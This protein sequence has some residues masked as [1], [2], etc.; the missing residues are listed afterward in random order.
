MKRFS[1]IIPVFNRPN[2]VDELLDSLTRQSLQNFEVL[3][4]EDGSQLRCEE[5]VK[6]YHDKL[7]LKYFFKDNSG[8]GL[9]RNYGAERATED[10]FIFFD[11]DCIIPEDYFKI[12]SQLYEKRPFHFYG[13]VDRAHSSFTPIQKAID[14]SMTSFLT[15]GGI[16]GGVKKVTKFYPRS[17]NMGFSREV[18]KATGGFSTMR[19]GEDIDFSLR[20]EREGF[21]PLLIN[22]AYVYHKRRTDFKKFYKQIFNSGI[23]RINLYKRFPH[24]LKLTHF[25]PAAFLIF[26][27]LSVLS[28]IL[29]HYALAAPLLVYLLMIFSDASLKKRS[30]QVGVIAV[31]ATLVQMIAYGSGFIKAVWVRLVLGKDE[32]SAFTKNFYK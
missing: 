4:I 24:S 6:K 17:F 1:V 11:S 29:F 22:E 2:E 28:A 27:V 9:S 14:Y 30:V 12:L 31:W 8:P 16:R 15:T 32:F 21:T 20:V 3:I 25:F 26:F 10:F 23:A 19:F 13:G 7:N 5:V 18:Y